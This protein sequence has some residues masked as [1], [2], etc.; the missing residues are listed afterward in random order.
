MSGRHA[1]SEQD[2]PVWDV[3]LM[4]DFRMPDSWY[5]PPDE[6]EQCDHC[7]GVGCISCDAGLLG[8]YLADLQMQRKKEE[9]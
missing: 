1:V 5:D 7:E 4:T 3:L 6:E 2:H 9:E 8:D